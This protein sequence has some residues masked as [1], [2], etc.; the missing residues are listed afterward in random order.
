MNIGE[1]ISLAFS[2]LKANKMRAFLTMLG[3]IIGISSVIMITTLGDILK[4]SVNKTVADMGTTNALSMFLQWKED[5]DT[6][7]YISE[8]DVFFTTENVEELK[9][10]FSGRVKYTLIQN[11]L[12][13]GTVKGKNKEYNVVV[14]GMSLDAV[15]SQSTLT[16]LEGRDFREED[17]KNSRN[18]IIITDK[19]AEYL[20]PD[21]DALGK[22]MEVKVNEET[23]PFVIIGIIEYKVSAMS[24]AMISAVGEDIQTQ[25]LIPYTTVNKLTGAS[26]SY[27]NIIVYS[28][29]G[30]DQTE[31]LDD[32]IKHYNTTY[33][34]TNESVEVTGLAAEQAID[35]LN[36]IM[37]TVELVITIIAGIS[38]MVGG[39]GVM[40]IMLVSVTERTR[41]IG[42][43]KA[44]GAPNGAIRMQFI[45]ESVIICLIGGIIGIIFGVVTGNIIGI[46]VDQLVPPSI[47]SIIIAVTFSMAI[48]V[49]FGYYPANKAAKLDPI[50]ALRYE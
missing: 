2:S 17:M 16:L 47:S 27:S 37:G 43:R 5:A 13:T 49:F 1:N 41:E 22:T 4:A 25:T 36:S 8:N 7:G 40:N 35:M 44:L 33:L 50:E 15:A 19:L 12:G 20:Y 9:S 38:L 46:I 42:V 6:D 45:V 14:N 32:I 21:G 28:E 34:R 3:I 31:L 18:V 11:Y 29:E 23:Y 39:I 10:Y 26:D 48:G 30:I 24:S